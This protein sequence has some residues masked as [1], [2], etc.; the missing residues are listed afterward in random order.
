MKKIKILKTT[1]S[2]LSNQLWNYVSIYAYTLERKFTIQNYSFFE[3]GNY[4]TMSAPNL[5]FRLFFFLPFTNYTKRKTSFKRRLWR[6]LYEYYTKIII[7]INKQ[8]VITSDNSENKPFYLPPTNENLKLSEFEKSNDDIYFDGWLFRNPIGIKKYREEIIEYFK[9]RQDIEKK[10]STQIKT[11]RSNYKNLIGVHVR[12][13]DYKE[14]RNG[15][16]F[17]P[18]IMVKEI[19]LEYLKT[20]GLSASET[21]FVITSDGP[22][23]TLLYSDLNL[24]ISK[25]NAVHDLFLLSSTD[26]I[27]GANSTFGAFASYYGDIPFVVMQKEQIDWGYYSDKK[28]YFENKYCTMVHF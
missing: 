4:F 7:S 13:G 12:Q 17:V 8:S 3:Y 23:E 2:E 28:S 18:Q 1:G 16:Y 10:V 9:P 19:I 11:L 5:F 15:A 24:Y 14:W 21:C 27:L 22:I 20:S 6:K 26:L 25:E